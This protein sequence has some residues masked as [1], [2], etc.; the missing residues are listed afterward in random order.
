MKNLA[1]KYH[2]GQT[3]QGDG[4]IPYI[5]HPRDVAETL[6]S[7]GEK[8]DSPLIEMAWGHDL[9]EDTDATEEEIFEIGGK[10]VLEAV[11]LLT[12]KQVGS[13]GNI[14]PPKTGK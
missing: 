2:A 12:K 3:R 8:E 11:K 13:N 5:V 14:I 7:W 9:L 6:I 4:Y 1:E 10:D